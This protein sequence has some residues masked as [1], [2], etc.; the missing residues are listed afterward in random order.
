MATPVGDSYTCASGGSIAAG[1]F[2]SSLSP[3]WEDLTA[4]WHELPVQ[5]QIPPGV[6]AYSGMT[7]DTS[8]G[9]IYAFGGGH[10]D[11]SDNSVWIY[12][13]E[14]RSTWDQLYT[15]YPP[16][17]P[18]VELVESLIDNVD[19]PGAII[20][21][22][23]APTFRPISRH[24]YRAVHWMPDR[25]CFVAGG[26]ST[27]SGNGDYLWSVYPNDPGDWWTYTPATNAWVYKGS[28]WA[29]YTTQTLDSAFP[30]KGSCMVYHQARGIVY[31]AT[32]NGNNNLEIREWNPDTGVWTV[33]PEITTGF[34][35]QY[36]SI[37]VDTLRDR[38]LVLSETAGSRVVAVHAFDLTT[39][40][41]SLLSASGDIPSYI[42][43]K[44]QIAYSPVTDRLL[45]ISGSNFGPYGLKAYSISTGVWADLS[46]SGVDCTHLSGAMCFDDSR[47]VLLLAAVTSSGQT[48]LYALKE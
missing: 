18:S 28:K 36:Q 3:F 39:N 17:S 2:V 41:W 5:T 30:I 7:V 12:D 4:G 13:L 47:D 6:L 45:L 21:A 23:S 32:M 44:Y 37:A 34:Y 1:R 43:E 48:K 19:Y 11:S 9:K 33:R 26:G 22:P 46:F 29:N 14:T 8:G 16:A 42:N 25:G 38:L 10:N 40:T 35:A 15:P 31:S 24:T 27:Y 20:G